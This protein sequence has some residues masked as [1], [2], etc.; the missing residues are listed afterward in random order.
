MNRTSVTNRSTK[1]DH[2]TSRFEKYAM[3]C[4]DNAEQDFKSFDA[5]QRLAAL[6]LKLRRCE[7]APWGDFCCLQSLGRD[8]DSEEFKKKKLSGL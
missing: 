5:R 8:F 2:L 7:K 3:A 6:R 4:S 1:A